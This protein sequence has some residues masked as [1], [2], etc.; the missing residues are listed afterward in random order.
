[1]EK[2][3]DGWNELKKRVHGGAR[4]PF[5]HAREIWWCSVGVN[6]GNELDGTGE[7]HDRPIVVI[8]P[9]NAETF[10][11]VSLIGHHRKGAYYFPIGKVEERDAVANLSQ[12]RLYDTKRLIRKITTLDE[13]IFDGLCE[14]LKSTLFPKT[15]LPRKAG[16]GRS[17]M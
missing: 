14:A 8:R 15:N 5:Y 1:M 13:R 6:V 12:A 4:R 16:R 3:F 2:D 11:G 10:F 9:F 17:H 7:R